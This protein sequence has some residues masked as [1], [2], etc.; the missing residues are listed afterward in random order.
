M[1]CSIHGRTQRAFSRRPL[2]PIL[3]NKKLI[4]FRKR[5]RGL[6]FNFAEILLVP[7][8][9]VQPRSAHMAGLERVGVRIFNRAGAHDRNW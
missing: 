9:V 6:D 8:K 4:L 2:T 1:S 5:F 3:I 7:F